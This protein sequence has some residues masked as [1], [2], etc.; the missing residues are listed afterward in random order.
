MQLYCE[1]CETTFE[2]ENDVRFYEPNHDGHYHCP[3]CGYVLDEVDGDDYD[4]FADGDPLGD[5]GGPNGLHEDDEGNL[6]YD[7]D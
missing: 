2:T 5:M 6:T 7:Y 4:P 1:N 3:D